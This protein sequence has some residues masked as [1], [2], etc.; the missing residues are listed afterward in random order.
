MK[1]IY[2]TL[3]S[4]AIRDNVRDMDKS[5]LDVRKMRRWCQRKSGK[6]ITFGLDLEGI[7]PGAKLEDGISEREQMMQRESFLIDAQWGGAIRGGTWQE[8]EA[9]LEGSR[10]P[11]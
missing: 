1:E 8:V 4:F 11:S 3:T 2:G 5:T 7:W 10:M 6:N 9:D